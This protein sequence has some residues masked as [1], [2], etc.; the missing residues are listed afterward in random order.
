MP[1]TPAGHMGSKVRPAGVILRVG[2]LCEEGRQGG[3]LL[4]PVTPL[5]GTL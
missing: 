4:L 2:R 5:T 3:A 1:E